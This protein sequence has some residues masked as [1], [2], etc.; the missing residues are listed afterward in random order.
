MDRRDHSRHL[1]NALLP[2]LGWGLPPKSPIEGGKK[3]HLFIY[4]NDAKAKTVPIVPLGFPESGI[5]TA[6]NFRWGIPPA[7]NPQRVR[8]RGHLFIGMTPTLKTVPSLS[9][10]FP[11]Y[12]TTNVNNSNWGLPLPATPKR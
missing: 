7:S 10:G 12:G 4:G 1:K 9:L 5:T 8:K 11:G 6:S 3:V 2:G